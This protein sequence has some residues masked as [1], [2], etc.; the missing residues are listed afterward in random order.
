MR[1]RRLRRR[2][3]LQL[4]FPAIF[5]IVI[6]DVVLSV[7]ATKQS[8]VNESKENT[9]FKISDGKIAKT[10]LHNNSILPFQHSNELIEWDSFCAMYH[11]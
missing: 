5:Y 9:E 6:L 7:S 11:I 8:D 1:M 2:Q 10:I 4:Q 3:P